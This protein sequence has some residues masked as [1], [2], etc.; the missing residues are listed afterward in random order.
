MAC[1]T[2]AVITWAFI[3]HRTNRN[4]Y[5][6]AFIKVIARD[7]GGLLK[8]NSN[9]CCGFHVLSDVVLSDSNNWLS[10]YILKGFT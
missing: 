7:M 2:M 9:F 5:I 1:F 6:S 4:P 3:G 8:K 10:Y